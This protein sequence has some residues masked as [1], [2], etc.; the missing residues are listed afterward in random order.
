MFVDT[1]TP[2]PISTIRIVDIIY[3]NP[4]VYDDI[5]GDIKTI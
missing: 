2:V 1:F 4:Y 5:S 3:F